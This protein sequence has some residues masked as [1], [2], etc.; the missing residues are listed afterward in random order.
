[1]LSAEVQQKTACTKLTFLQKSAQGDHLC[2]IH[3]YQKSIKILSG[4]LQ[5]HQ[6]QPK[7]GE[8]KNNE[9]L[10]RWPNPERSLRLNSPKTIARIKDFCSEALALLQVRKIYKFLWN[11]C[12]GNDQGIYGEQ[13]LL[14][15]LRRNAQA[16]QSSKKRKHR[17]WGT[18]DACRL[19]IYIKK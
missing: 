6:M 11:R 8:P 17:A 10:K 14:E 18:P 15:I 3:I 1:M 13:V 12:T 5:A 19:R 7:N 4:D 9:K 16:S 2:E